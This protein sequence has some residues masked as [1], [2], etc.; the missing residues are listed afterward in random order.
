[1][2]DLL[3]ICT[4]ISLLVK[5]RA[6]SSK[7]A[8]LPAGTNLIESPT[9]D[10]FGP[11]IM[12]TLQGDPATII[13]SHINIYSL[14][15]HLRYYFFTMRSGSAILF[16]IIPS[17]DIKRESI[18]PAQFPNPCSPEVRVINQPLTIITSVNTPKSTACSFLF[19]SARTPKL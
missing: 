14:S 17:S 11:G 9:T 1:M 15:T 10:I 16:L 8:G 6:E 19:T 13:L 5:P 4:S 7:S 12:P 18:F 3:I 2:L